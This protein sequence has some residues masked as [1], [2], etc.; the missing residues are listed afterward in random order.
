MLLGNPRRARRQPLAEGFGIGAVREAFNAVGT[1]GIL[2]KLS[3]EQQRNLL[4][5]FTRPPARCWTSVSRTTW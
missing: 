3:L 1:A 4:D 2:R 5:L